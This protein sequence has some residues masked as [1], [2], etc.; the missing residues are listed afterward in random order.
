[1]VIIPFCA[2]ASDTR[3]TAGPSFFGPIRTEVVEGAISVLISGDFDE[4][5]DMD[6]VTVIQ[7]RVYLLVGRGNGEFQPPRVLPDIVVNGLEITELNG[8]QHLDLIGSAFDPKQTWILLG[9]GDGT[10][11]ARQIDVV[12]EAAGDLNGDGTADLAGWTRKDVD[13]PFGIFLNVGDGTF[14]SQTVCDLEYAGVYTGGPVAV[15]DVNGDE[16]NDLLKLTAKSTPFSGLQNDSIVLF[17]NGDGTFREGPR[18]RIG[19]PPYGALATGY[20]NTGAK[21]DIV[22]AAT[23]VGILLGQNDGNF[24]W[25]TQQPYAVAN[26]VTVADLDMD[27]K[28]D[29]VTASST[30]M[31]VFPGNGDGTLKPVVEFGRGTYGHTLSVADFDGDGRPDLAVASI[32]DCAGGVD[33]YLNTSGNPAP[34]PDGLAIQENPSA[35]NISWAP[36]MEGFTLESTTN[37]ALAAWQPV[38]EITNTNRGRWPVA[39]G[40]GQPQEFFRLRKA[41]AELFPP[42]HPPVTLASNDFGSLQAAI[43]GEVTFAFDG[44]IAFTNTLAIGADTT[45]D[46]TGH[47][48]VLDGGGLVRHFSVAEGV[49]LRLINLTLVNGR[50]EPPQADLR[51]DG[52]PGLGG[53]IYTR[54]GTVELIGCKFLNNHAVGGRGG[55][56]AQCL[57]ATPQGTVGAAAYGGAIAAL[58]GR[59]SMVGCLFSGNGCTG[60]EGTPWEYTVPGGDAYGGAVYLTNSTLSLRGTTLTNNFA[61]GGKMQ[62]LMPTGWAGGS[63]FGGA[64][65]AAG[66]TGSVSGCV[67]AGNRVEGAE[68]LDEPFGSANGGA[69]FL[70]SGELEL[71]ETLLA[72]NLAQGGPGVTYWWFR[73]SLPRSS[74]TGRGGAVCQESGWLRLRNCAVVSNQVIGG[75]GRFGEP[76]KTVGHGGPA[77]GGGIYSGMGT[78]TLTNCTIA[79]NSVTGGEAD[80]QGPAEGG[81]LWATNGVM[82]VNVTVA[83]NSVTGGD[84]TG[85]S[86]LFGDATLINTILACASGQANV[87]GTITDGG[88]NISSDA[89][90]GFTASSSRA[91]LDP[92]LDPPADNGGPTPTMALLSGSPAIDAADAS[93]CP[94]TD[95]RGVPRPSGPACDIGAFEL[96]QGGE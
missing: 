16:R 93:A 15:A 49:T 42:V 23:F 85:G 25:T 36:G 14:H 6:L 47:E 91:S 96:E 58:D 17:G 4:D 37:L 66:S 95:Q 41:V 78:L 39:A 75:F 11:E 31:A 2:D 46:G 1:M 26:G 9:H 33:I 71:E 50:H 40:T 94:Q 48:V 67:L 54:G 35:I 57:F 24:V 84:L 20:F 19:G 89:S 53:S 69:L 79:G 73:F 83:D 77:L 70:A 80:R 56:P 43:H 5:G 68:H 21:L 27:G 82:L 92:M 22:V 3:S 87:A 44:T 59:V 38:T 81:A 90:A 74:G 45:L 12:L 72:E 8:D 7:S 64:V 63:A 86:S 61:R 52:T 62:G 28:A 34:P 88:S 32:V 51:K 29:V 30:T 10:F 76:G 18:G 65:A 60:G 55:E 13:A